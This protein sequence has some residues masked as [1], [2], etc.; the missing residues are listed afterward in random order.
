VRTKIPGADSCAF[1]ICCTRSNLGGSW[2]PRS[3]EKKGAHPQLGF[4]FEIEIHFSKSVLVFGQTEKSDG[5][6][7][8]VEGGVGGGADW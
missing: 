5:G 6:A 4:H 8:G 2:E 3:F 1:T 7:D